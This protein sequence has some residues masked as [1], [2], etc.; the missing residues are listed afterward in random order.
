LDQEQE[1]DSEGRNCG[2]EL[3]WALET[4]PDEF[5]P[6]TPGMM[7]L[8]M[9]VNRGLLMDSCP[10]QASSC[11]AMPACSDE[12]DGMM[13]GGTPDM[14]MEDMHPMLMPLLMC[15]AS[16]E[17]VDFHFSTYFI[18]YSATGVGGMTTY[19]LLLALGGS[20]SNVYAL[21]G[22]PDGDLSVPPAY[23]VAAPFGAD[24]GGVDPAFFAFSAAA[25]F[26]SWLTVGITDDDSGR[27]G[28][29]G[30][31]FSSWTNT[32][33]FSTDNGAIFWMDPGDGPS[34]SDIVMAQ[35][36]VPSGSDG[37]ASGVLQG[38]PAEGSDDW[39]AVATWSWTGNRPELHCAPVTLTDTG[40]VE[41]ADLENHQTCSWTM[42][43][44][45]P[46]LVPHLEFHEF[47]TE[48]WYDYLHLHD[49]ESDSSSRLASLHG[50]V[51]PSGSIVG[52]G[53]VLFALYESDLSVNG[54]GFNASFTCVDVEQVSADPC[55]GSGVTLVDS[56]SVE[57]VAL[58]N[59]Q[60]CSWRLNCSNSAQL[61][62][63]TF[64]TFHTERN[65]DFVHLHDGEEASVHDDDFPDVSL[66]GRDVPAEPFVASGPAGLVRYTSDGSVNR[67]GFS[68]EFTCVDASVL[69]TVNPCSRGATLFDSGTFS[70][71]ATANHQLCSWTLRCSDATLAPWVSFSA[72]STETDFVANI[73]NAETAT[74]DSVALHGDSVPDDF[75]GTGPVAFVLFDSSRSL[76]GDGF[77][78]TFS[79][80]EPQEPEPP[81][82]PEPE[83]ESLVD[84]CVGDGQSLWDS[85]T[86]A[87]SNLQNGQ[88]CQ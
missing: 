25:E 28:Y 56:G 88:L 10:A 72:F 32:S 68:A 46:S 78:A 8:F 6:Q 85:G 3:T 49:G 2:E 69:A 36:T 14:E 27:L 5:T 39:Q 42:E 81:P 76:V 79:C 11:F 64:S 61:A 65:F 15:M 20:A 55:V 37:S 43:C 18:T 24:I 4:N 71:S 1:R 62:Q 59:N 66:H 60:E 63:L 44:S 47:H 54:N 21:A 16:D 58:T 33:G 9:C 53:S 31:D 87:H 35:L 34:G 41:H 45:D 50:H 74:G 13:Q 51:V 40:V 12:L 86:V 38:R 80:G 23:Q 57:H 77:E 52:T 73:F 30:P 29:A 7:E 70:H 83:P 48:T 84:P 75:I 19:R 22:T 82:E 67:D 17:L 26:D